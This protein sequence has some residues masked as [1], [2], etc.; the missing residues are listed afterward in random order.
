MKTVAFVYD[1]L[2]FKSVS[3]IINM[4]SIGFKPDLVIAA[5]KI[6]LAL[7]P[8]PIKTLPK[9]FNSLDPK[10]ICNLLSIPLI[11]AHHNSEEVAETLREMNADLGIILGAR[12]LKQPIIDEF[13]MGILN[14]HAGLIPENRGLDNV[15]WAVVDDVPQGVTSHLIDASIDAG[16]I[17]Q[18]DTLKI[19]Q[20]D[21]T[22]DLQLKLMSLEQDLLL[23]TLQRFEYLS[24]CSHGQTVHKNQGRYHSV[25]TASSAIDFESKFNRYR[26]KWSSEKNVMDYMLLN[27]NQLYRRR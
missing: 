2:H 13:K 10:V 3:G 26:Q 4:S 25:M 24:V 14:L 5:P 27:H 20:D 11:V 9:Q 16:Q 17:L 22:M 23:D 12:I 8:S 6:N 7:P 19:E 15:Q 21:T 18:M 1:F